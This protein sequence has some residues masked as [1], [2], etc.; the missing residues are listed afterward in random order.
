MLSTEKCRITRSQWHCDTQMIVCRWWQRASDQKSRY[1]WEMLGDVLRT[2]GGSWSEISLQV[3]LLHGILYLKKCLKVRQKLGTRKVLKNLK[4]CLI[5]SLSTCWTT[6][7]FMSM[8]KSHAHTLS[9]S[10]LSLLSQLSPSHS[11]SLDMLNNFCF[12][13][14]AQKSLYSWKCQWFFWTSSSAPYPLT[15]EFIELVPS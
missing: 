10:L 11:L 2:Q 15:L 3:I 7:V 4:N 14:Y 8:L 13:V 12:H 1:P 6:F 9:L 5:H